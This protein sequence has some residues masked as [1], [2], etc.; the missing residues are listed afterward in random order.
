[1]DEREDL[2]RLRQKIKSDI[3]AMEEVLKIVSHLLDNLDEEYKLNE[4]DDEKLSI[5]NEESVRQY[6]EYFFQK[7]TDSEQF[8]DPSFS[9]DSEGDYYED[10]DVISIAYN[11]VDKCLAIGYS[12][13]FL[14]L[15][16]SIRVY[17]V[18]CLAFSLKVR[19]NFG[20]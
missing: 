2:I 6:L 18:Q 14:E 3:H 20:P 11:S 19:E 9:E 16:E 7:A 13:F 12:H 4:Q 1:M 5:Q 10:G 15:P 8:E 17:I